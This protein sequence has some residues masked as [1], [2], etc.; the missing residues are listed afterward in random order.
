M[1]EVIISNNGSTD[2]TVIAIVQ[3]NIRRNYLIYVLST[4]LTSQEQHTPGMLAH[5]LLLATH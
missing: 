3:S 2:E 1:E 4:H 5:W